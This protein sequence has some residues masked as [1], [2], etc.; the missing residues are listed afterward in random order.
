MKK[1]IALIFCLSLSVFAHDNLN[2]LPV[3][4]LKKYEQELGWEITDENG[5]YLGK[6]INDLINLVT[7]EECIMPKNTVCYIGQEY[8]FRN[9]YCPAYYS[10]TLKI[11]GIKVESLWD[12]YICDFGRSGRVFYG[13]KNAAHKI[14]KF[15]N[16]LVRAG[17]CN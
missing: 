10:H 1:I 3:C 6:G 4:K 8:N 13:Y 17:I 2:E 9:D 12:Y 7:Q 11:N 5:N 16:T 14:K 15:R